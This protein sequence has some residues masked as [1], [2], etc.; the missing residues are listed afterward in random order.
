MACSAFIA[1]VSGAENF[2]GQPTAI[3]PSVNSLGMKFVPVPKTKVLFSVWDTRVCDFEAFVK[4]TGIQASYRMLSIGKSGLTLK[5]ATWRNPGFA[6]GPTHP[7][8]GVSW[9]EAHAFCA[10]LTKRERALGN[11]GKD[12]LYRLPTDKEWGVAVGG[13]KCAYGGNSWP[14]PPN[15]ANYAGSE[16]GLDDMAEPWGVISDPREVTPGYQDAY[17]RTSPVAAFPPNR[18]GLYDM[19]GN[20]WQWCEDYYRASM[21]G[22]L[23]RQKC[24]FLQDEGIIRPYRVLRGGSWRTTSNRLVR[25]D[26]RYP[27]IPN[28]SSDNT[29]FRCVL[30]KEDIQPKAT[31]RIKPSAAFIPVDVTTI[32]DNR[33]R[34]QMFLDDSSD[35]AVAKTLKPAPGTRGVSL[36]FFGH[37]ITVETCPGTWLNIHLMARNNPK[38]YEAVGLPEGLALDSVKGIITGK[39]KQ[40]GTYSVKIV[41]KNA[42][43][44]GSGILKIIV[45]DAPAQTTVE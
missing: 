12:Q 34:P 42:D 5:A 9:Y 22:W 10:W 16:S 6:Q 27:G 24:E 36:Y 31:K 29:G 44:S 25:S 13:G 43:G 26:V 28:A 15:V 41:A 17:P 39:V 14:P 21:N 20:V 19:G 23:L 37:M 1:P 3:S 4:S 11:I 38:S 7:V 35:A 32:V 30:A 2:T 45:A 8:V 33:N 40:P 18:Y